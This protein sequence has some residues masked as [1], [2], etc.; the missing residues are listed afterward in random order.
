MFK[1][2]KHSSHHSLDTNVWDQQLYDLFFSRME[3][4]DRGHSFG[5][6]LTERS[7]TL[8]HGLSTEHSYHGYFRLIS[9][10]YEDKY[11]DILVDLSFHE[12]GGDFRIENT[13]FGYAEF[14][15]RDTRNGRKPTIVLL[16]RETGKISEEL[17]QLFIETKAC[18]GEGVEV[19]FSIDINDILDL[20]AETVWGDWESFDYDNLPGRK[21]FPFGFLE[22]CTSIK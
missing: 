10:P 11:C 7:S 5:F 16:V 3:K 15:W 13:P 22:F 4:K 19:A 8:A 17:S 9:Y 20:N 6:M 1:I 14:G 2:K 18:G 21:S 12:Q